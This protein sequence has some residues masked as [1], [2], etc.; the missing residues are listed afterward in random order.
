[1]D[2]QPAKRI[3]FDKS[4]LF[5]LKA[6]VLKKQEEIKNK[7]RLP[8][9]KIENFKPPPAKSSE[10]DCKTK[11]KTKKTFKDSLRAVDI[12]EVEAIKKAKAVLEKKA[13]LYEH[14]SNPMGESQMAGRFLVD[15]GKRRD[16]ESD[17]IRKCN[18][19][20]KPE[21]PLPIV[22]DNSCTME[23]SSDEDEWT[24]Y[25]DCLGRTRTCPKT[26][27]QYLLEKDK[28]LKKEIFEE[29]EDVHQPSTSK[30]E[31]SEKPFL[32]QKTNDYLKSLR[33]KWEEKE[34]EILAKNYEDIHY[35]DLLFDEAR[36]HGVGYFSFST[37]AAE[38]QR[39]MDELM[40]R[41][42]ETLREQAAMEEKTKQRDEMLAAR[43]KAA[44]MR[45]R[46]RAGLPPDDAKLQYKELIID[47]LNQIKAD[48]DKR[49]KEKEQQIKEEL[50]KE[51]QKLREA[52]VREWDR[53]KDGVDEKVKKFKEMTQ[54]EYVEQQR[55]KRIDEFAPLPTTSSSNTDS[56]MNDKV[57][58][59]PKKTPVCTK[60]W[61]DVLPKP[62]TPPP[63]VICD[64][65][66]DTENKKG[67]YFSTFK[68][69]QHNIQYKN[70]VKAQEPT[71]IINELSDGESDGESKSE[72]RQLESDHAEIPPPP[73]YEYYGP[74]AKKAKSHKP[75][76]S[77]IREA[78]A[79]GTK[80]LEP[81]A[82]NR[83]LP[84][85][86]DFSLG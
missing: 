23:N 2:E 73:T 6:E 29:E 4:T 9:Y 59:I 52:H 22:L 60:T 45:Q 64:F 70:F 77:D 76:E 7:K 1:M 86:Y 24:E 8:E 44:R 26:D 63:P 42:E 17:K 30:E 75:F 78:F 68:K 5:N 10:N 50:E 51:R 12:E 38:R 66:S 25:V 14:L 16:I 53:G 83:R 65:T 72:K 11:E 56:T 49:A 27:L 36:M 46:I 40:K 31:I 18:S 84:Q 3:L 47:A 37:D 21:P 74:Q 85:Q 43:V 28:N 55:S 79:Q 33:E 15:F 39:Q 69:S 82:S 71:A 13:E 81:K 61:S 48:Q 80:N 67:L 20:K 19:E 54:E 41:R 35:Q 34:R 62:K 57:R 58:L 32:V